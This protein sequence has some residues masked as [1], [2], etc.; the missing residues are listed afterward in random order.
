VQSTAPSTTPS[1]TRAA[2]TQQPDPASSGGART[3]AAE[4]DEYAFTHPCSIGHLSVQVTRRAGAP[5]QRVIAVRNTGA[6]VC[7]LTYY[8]LVTLD[9]SK[10]QDGTAA[11][12]PLVPGGLGGPPAYPVRPGRTAYAEVDLDPS[13]ATTGTAAGVDELN[14]LP[15]GDHMPAAQTLN[16]PL[17][18][19]TSVL[20]PK[21][22]LYRD[23]VSDAAA[24]MKTAD[25]QP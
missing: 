12:T 9:S 3:G 4:P 11:V 2:P 16:F 25:M 7:G 14:V 6:H 20:K 1:T 5:T 15:D 19:G 13:G 17:A 18:K 24:S 21:L 23:T 8:P 10:A 22:G